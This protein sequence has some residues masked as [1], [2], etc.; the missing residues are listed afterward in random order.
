MDGAILGLL[1]KVY[2]YAKYGVDYGA[3]E[4]AEGI[5]SA[6][7][8]AVD[9]FP[10]GLMDPKL[11]FLVAKQAVAA[12]ALEIAKL[13]IDG[14]EDMEK[15]VDKGLE[16]LLKEVGSS[17]AL[18]VKEIFFEGDMDGMLKG[19][20]LILTMDLEVFGDDLG[21]QMFAFKL[22]DPLF[23]AEQLAFIPL[24]MV[25]ELFKKYAPSGLKQILGPI[26]V[27]IDNET[28]EAEQKVYAELK[29]IPGLKLPADVKEAL[30]QETSLYDDVINSIKFAVAENAILS[31]NAVYP[32]FIGLKKE[33]Q[34][35]PLIQLAALNNA[36]VQIDG[37]SPFIMLAQAQAQA[38]P[39]PAPSTKGEKSLTKA[40]R[41][42]IHPKDKLAA[43]KEKRRNLM[44]HIVRRN[45]A[46]GE[47]IV[48]FNKERMAEM[49]KNENDMYVAHTDV[50]VP[51][52]V[53]FSERLLVARHAKLCLG[54]T[55]QKKVS[56]HP[57]NENT[58]GLL[59]ST[60]RKLVDLKG[61]MIPWNPAF[62]KRFP[63]RVYTQIINNGSCLTT[64]F[65]LQ[66]YDAASKQ[67][68][69]QQVFEIAK[70]N[71]ASTAA[72]LSLASCRNDGKGQL[73]KV[74]KTTHHANSKNHGFKLQERDTAFCLR[75]DSVKGHTKKSSKEVNG[76]FY[77]CTGIAHGT[78]ELTIPNSDMP[79]WYDHNGVIK[80]DNGYCLNVPNDPAADADAT[81]SPVYLKKCSDDEY[82][83]WDYVVEYDK[84]VKIINDF[85][86]HCLYP[87]DQKEG[88]IPSA[89]TG[90]L[91]Q[92]PCDARYGQGWKMRVIPEQM[93][94]Q[95]EAKGKTNKATNNC[96]I[97][98]KPSPKNDKVKVF[99]K[100][101]APATRGRWQFGH[102]KGNYEWTEWTLAN[103]VS[104]TGAN[105]STTYWVSK[106]SLVN[107]NKNGVC[108]A[109]LGN[110][111]T[112][113][114]YSIY[115]GTWRGKEGTCSYVANGK[116]IA[117]NPS[118]PTG[119]NI[120]VE[121]LSGVSIGVSGS[122][123]SW[124]SS[125]GVI[126]IDGT[127]QNT[128]PPT[129]KF[130]PFLAG[131]DATYPAFYLCRIKNSLDRAW[132]YGYQTTS[133]ACSTDA[134]NQ[135]IGGSEVLVFKT[136]ANAVANN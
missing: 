115:P 77:P 122:T 8:Y 47:N 45:K 71:P 10:A 59:W 136:V 121:V 12:A 64:P 48:N 51:P 66:G 91:V 43:F 118:Q 32:Q 128:H 4:V 39:K 63:N 83:R 126:P 61:H 119:S 98:A 124:K 105:L 80:T 134:G 78:F 30:Q 82:D 113:G 33:A 96:M 35:R 70:N 22:T 135:T 107:K 94:F 67:A 88:K 26:F 54:Q 36:D 123:G 120:L 44:T 85:T 58:G 18:V 57:C 23:D 108:R 50:L 132:R 127:G 20:P 87:Y 28:N 21:T 130:S 104:S 90:Q 73:W 11:D 60:R 15:W 114:S 46:F 29:N 100:S 2:Y 27:M 49:A 125:S 31:P 62:V 24:H 42:K 99:V 76:S 95:L 41:K 111:D 116:I 65:H 16:A 13:A 103:S 6:A 40:E 68:H 131:G 34:N 14:V 56:F 52:G 55:A 1:Y 72:H 97:P 89:V 74:V 25:S 7:E 102:W 92:R 112:G 109:I 38:K 9:H 93:W 3:W 53:L 110:H 84:T 86:G 19:S 106:D 37:A 81:G 133:T 75:P 69:R 129:P 117:F 79:I 101:C 17:D 5:L